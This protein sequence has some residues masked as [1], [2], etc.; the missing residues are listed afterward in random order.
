[1][2]SIELRQQRAALIVDTQNWFQK[3]SEEGNLS[4]A[5]IEQEWA[6]RNAE[7]DRLD[8]EQR[9]K[10]KAE[11]LEHLTAGLSEPVGRK[12]NPAAPRLNT[13]PTKAERNKA[14]KAWMAYGNGGVRGVAYDGDTMNRCAELGFHLQNN[15]VTY[16]SMNTSTGGAG[17]NS[18]FTTTYPDLQT[19]LKYYSPILDKVNVQVTGDGNNLVLPR[20][21]DVANTMA[22]VSQ[23]GSSGTSTDPTFDKVTLGSYMFRYVEQVTYEMLQDAVFDVE[24]WITARLAER[25]A[26]TL[27]KYIVSGTGSSQPTGLIAACTAADGGTAAVTLAATKKNFYQFED[28]FSLFQ[29]V[30]LAYRAD[31]TLVLHD[32]SVWDLRK[33]KDSNGRYIWDVNNTL[34]QN[35]QP[36]KVAGF[37]YLVS[38]SID[39]S[40]SFS[41]NIAVFANLP[42]QVVRIADGVQITRLNELYR[43]NGMIG[44]EVLLRFD[45]NYVGHASSIARV[46]TPAS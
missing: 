41:K 44:F 43:G 13:T 45:C 24:G 31:N 30:D 4:E 36:D 23:A 28:L 9:K 18:T 32:S 15:T 37:N 8:A 7:I 20:G 40:G 1:M 3:A 39:A 46:A 12:T 27:E 34:V 25:A 26:R 2:N 38:N 5:E 29:S 22:I 14:L 42:R 6:K 33:I 17:G 21:S 16:R 10:E 11:R 35:S 19:E